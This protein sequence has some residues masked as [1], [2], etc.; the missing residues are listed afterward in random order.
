[1]PE[2]AWTSIYI[3][4]GLPFEPLL[5]KG[6]G[7]FVE[8][9]LARGWATGW[10]FVRYGEEGPHIRL[11]IK[12]D[13][14]L[15]A[16]EARAWFARYLGQNP[17]ERPLW[18]ED[19]QLGARPNNSLYFPQY[20]PETARYGGER[21]MAIAERQF[22]LS[23]QAVLS[24]LT[25]DATWDYGK[26][27]GI[28]V[29]LHLVGASAFGLGA[30]DLERIFSAFSHY[31]ISRAEGTVPGTPPEQQYRAVQHRFEAMYQT[32]APVL[33]AALSDLWLPNRSGPNGP[34][35]LKE[36]HRGMTA[37]GQAFRN[38]VKDGALRYRIPAYFRRNFPAFTVLDAIHMSL[39]HMTNNR[40]GILNGDE[41]YMGYLL[42]KLA[43]SFHPEMAAALS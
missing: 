43:A 16:R 34:D 18:M 26:A 17:S 9:C 21:G 38:A 25:E 7:P 14:G 1:M 29:Q 39:L 19:P 10:F 13:P 36:W 11:R 41:A 3:F 27:L 23:S 6:I 32:Q 24:V 4:H 12:G 20:H 37:V 35:W 15:L 31:W 33:E 40:L 30:A 28:A 42:S 5:Q 22:C 8:F 2:R